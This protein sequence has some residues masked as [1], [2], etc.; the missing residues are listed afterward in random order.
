MAVV[1]GGGG[2]HTAHTLTGEGVTDGIGHQGIMMGLGGRRRS[3][4][5]KSL[6]G[7]YA[8][9]RVSIR[10]HTHPELAILIHFLVN[11]NFD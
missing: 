10:R 1:G 4:A 7:L 5:E 11:W 9:P 3:Q 2:H 8:L 6:F